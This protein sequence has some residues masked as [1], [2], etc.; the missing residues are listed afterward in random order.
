MAD[1]LIFLKLTFPADGGGQAPGRPVQGESSAEGF[2]DLIEVESLAWELSAKNDKAKGVG[3]DEPQIDYHA[4]TVN[5]HFDRASLAMLNKSARTQAA[6]DNRQ[7]KRTAFQEAVFTYVEMVPG[8]D[9]ADS[10]LQP[11]IQI[12][13]KDGYV[14]D[15]KLTVGESGNSMRVSET[16]RLSFTGITF[17]YH[18]PS[19]RSDQR[20][21]SLKFDGKTGLH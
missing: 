8:V 12:R 3:N 20:R 6:G 7:A 2:R 13:I 18:Y 9:G 21:A 15:L 4:V 1:T 19:D 16:V 11:V 17:Q 5:K 10:T 14:E